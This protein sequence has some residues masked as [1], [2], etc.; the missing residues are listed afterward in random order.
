MLPNYR[1]S[2][3]HL[4]V[5]IA[6]YTYQK[7]PA[8]QLFWDLFSNQMFQGEKQA[9]VQ[10]AFKRCN[11]PEIITRVGQGATLMSTFPYT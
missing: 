6:S 4:Q 3:I 1:W 2:R 5:H 7:Q 11:I 8:E 9:Y 10:D